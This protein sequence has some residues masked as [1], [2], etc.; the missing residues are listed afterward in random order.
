MAAVAIV[1][2]VVVVVAVAMKAALMLVVWGCVDAGIGGESAVVAVGVAGVPAVVGRV[3]EVAEATT[4]KEFAAPA[5]P[6]P[7]T[8]KG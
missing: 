5:H 6:R 3:A 1:V 7:H 8:R 4:T 2:A